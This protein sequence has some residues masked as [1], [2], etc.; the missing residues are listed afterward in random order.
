[1]M[2]VFADKEKQHVSASCSGDYWPC[3]AVVQTFGQNCKERDPQKRSR[4]EAD[5]RA[6]GLVLQ[7]QRG[8]DSSTAKRKNISRE[9][10]PQ[11]HLTIHHFAFAEGFG[12]H[13]RSA[14]LPTELGTPLLFAVE[15]SSVVKEIRVMAE[16][17]PCEVREGKPIPSRGMSGDQI[18]HSTT[19]YY[20]KEVFTGRNQSIFMMEIT[21]MPASNSKHRWQ[22]KSRE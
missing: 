9:D 18:L 20:R 16:H 5:E 13:R 7:A 15:R 1:M 3:A 17:W 21:K 10:L 2:D 19:N 11:D 6:K 14:P 22:A 8:A 12:C 4:R